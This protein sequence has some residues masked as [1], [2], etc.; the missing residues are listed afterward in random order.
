MKR[1]NAIIISAG[2]K[3]G[4]ADCIRIDKVAVALKKM[5]R[6]E[7]SGLSGL[8]AEMIQATGDIGTQYIL[9]LCNGIVKEVCIP[10]D[11]KS[12]VILYY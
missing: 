4:P 12:S 8:V 7:A 11:W 1:M 6:H 5:K 3:E 2:V 10:E 9:D